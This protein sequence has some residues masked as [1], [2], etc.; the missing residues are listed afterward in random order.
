[1]GLSLRS[2]TIKGLEW[3]IVDNAISIFVNFV[4]SIVLARLLSPDDFGLLGLTLIFTTI[5][6]PIIN[7]GLGSA[8]IRKKNVLDIDY[9]TVFIA[10]LITSVIV[11]LLLFVSANFIASFFDRQELSSLIRVS[12]V[13]LIVSSFAIV[14]KVRLTRNI[15]FKTQAKVTAI[16]S[17][18]SCIIGLLF[19]I[20]GCGVWSLIYLSLSKI[21]L[22]SVLLFYYNSWCPK[23]TF[24]LNSFRYLFNYGWKIMLSDTLDSIWMEANHLV[25]GKIYS[26]ST[27]GQYTRSSQF[28]SLFSSNLTTIVQRVSFPVLSTIQDDKE[29]MEAGFKKIFKTTLFASSISL[30]FLGSISEPLIYCLLGTKWHEASDYLPIM[31]VAG[32]I[33]PLLAINQNILQ[34][35]GRSDL[36]LEL[37]IIKRV[38]G[39]FPIIVGA[40]VGIRSMLIASVVVL[41]ITFIF[42]SQLVGRLINYSTRKQL[43]DVFSFYVIALFV[44][45]TIY[46]IKYIGFTFWVILPLQLILGCTIILSICEFLKLEEY[47]E[48]KNF[49]SSFLRIKKH[50]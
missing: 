5:F 46:P 41:A 47:Y 18:V 31:C 44:A 45:I 8:L 42:F 37:S 35:I 6:T 50:I 30:F 14:Q 26:P 39:I 25:V 16:S 27:L 2:K 7:G 49:V 15:D 4:F 17:L 43:M 24:S 48:V 13:G 38:L 23:F 11:Y 19:V 34:V 20:A 33:Y 10:N 12:S 22:Q 1:M 28:L 32:T 29:Q 36:F 3:S 21:C 40:I 9:N